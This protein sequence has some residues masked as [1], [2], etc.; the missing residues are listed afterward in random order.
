MFPS[1]NPN[2]KVMFPFGTSTGPIYD[3]LEMPKNVTVEWIEQHWVDLWDARRWVLWRDYREVVIKT[4]YK[5]LALLTYAGYTDSPNMLGYK[6]YET[7]GTT[8]VN[9]AALKSWNL[10]S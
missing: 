2:K 7:I 4:K 1:N 5:L 6:V 3:P 9:S 8:M 10:G